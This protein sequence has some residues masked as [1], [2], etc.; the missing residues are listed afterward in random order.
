MDSKC[1]DLY[2]NL[3]SCGLHPLHVSL[4]E[5]VE[6]HRKTSNYLLTV[7]LSGKRDSDSFFHGK[8]C[9]SPAIAVTQT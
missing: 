8:N 7:T 6:V 2:L 5:G 3:G 1:Y 9:L 4:L